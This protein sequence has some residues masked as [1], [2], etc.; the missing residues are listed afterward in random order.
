MRGR[1]RCRRSRRRRNVALDAGAGDPAARIALIEVAIGERQARDRAAEAAVID[2][3][4]AK[5]W[6]DRQ[7]GEMRAHRV[8]ADLDGAGRQR[9]E[10]HL[11]WP[12]GRMVPTTEPSEKMRPMPAVPSKQ[13]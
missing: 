7:A 12:P 1:N 13:V 8:A 2:L 6:L 3:L 9:R 11:A 4:H 5:A 10:T